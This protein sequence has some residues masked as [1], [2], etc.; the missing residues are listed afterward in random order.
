MNLR[1]AKKRHISLV[2]GQRLIAHFLFVL[3]NTHIK[4]HTNTL[5]I[6]IPSCPSEEE[7]EEEEE[8][9]RY[10]SLSDH[11]AVACLTF[12]LPLKCAGRINIV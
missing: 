7:G 11:P 3:I 4:D 8:V 6:V 12:C 10:V 9:E 1:M 2:M 5:P